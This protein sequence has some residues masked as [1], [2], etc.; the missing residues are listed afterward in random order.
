VLAAGPRPAR[1]RMV[2]AL[3][4]WSDLTT[5]SGPSIRDLLSWEAGAQQL[6]VAYCDRASP[7]DVAAFK[8]LKCESPEL[9]I[10]ALCGS[11]DRRA[12]RRLIDSGVDG[13]VFFD[14]LEAA[15]APT[16]A[17]VFAGQMVVPRDLRSSV[18]KPA[19]SL[20]ERQILGMVVTGLTNHEI[21]SR[22]FLAESTVKSHLSS[23]YNKLGVRSRSE[24]IALI[25]DRNGSL[26]TENVAAAP[27]AELRAA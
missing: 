2:Q 18:D 6:V 4:V 9:L 20:R 17:A 13:L 8:Q 15:L 12:V 11:V 10:V 23:T 5:H 1:L 16:V 27:N 3:A 19:L 25:L 7:E 21:S 24:A 26:G 22:M 14:Q